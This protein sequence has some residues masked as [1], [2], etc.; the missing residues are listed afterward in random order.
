MF[1]QSIITYKKNLT[2]SNVHAQYGWG[3]PQRMMTILWANLHFPPFHNFLPNRAIF[4]QLMS[5]IYSNVH[6]KFGLDPMEEENEKVILNFNIPPFAS[7]DQSALSH[8]PHCTLPQ[9]IFVLSLDRFHEVVFEKSPIQRFKQ[10]G[11]RGL[12]LTMCMK[13][14]PHFMCI[15]NLLTV[16]I[17]INNYF[18]FTFTRL[19]EKIL[20]NCIENTKVKN[21][22]ANT[23]FK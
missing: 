21:S 2:H 23:I 16:F 1:N 4:T 14:I 17:K 9:G 22:S 3:R 6:V 11:L 18:S 5:L 20:L 12:H 19:N 8:L 15:I 13:N 10:L 7:F